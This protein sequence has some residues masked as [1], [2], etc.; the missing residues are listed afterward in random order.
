MQRVL[1]WL[2]HRTGYRNMV[3][4]ALYEPIPGGARWR[5]VWGSTLVFTFMIQVIT[6]FCLWLAYSPSATTAWE[7]VY[8]IQESMTLGWVIRG[9]HHF[10]A[11][12]MVILLVLH[13]M[14][15]VIDGAY[16][17]PREVNFWLG[18][19]LMQIILFLGLTG[20][21][22]PWD[23]KGYYAT[24]V[25]T[26]IMGSAPLVGP[27]MQQLLQGG[28]QY[29]NHTLT[30]FFALHAGLLPALLV[31]FL[32]LH[33]YVFRRHGLHAPSVEGRETGLFWPDQVLRDGV[34]CLAVLAAILT[35]TWYWHGAELMAP[36]DPSEAY[37]AAR[38]E[39]YYLFLFK[40]LKFPIVSQIGE[41][42]HLGEAFGAIVVPGVIMLVLVLM[43]LIAYIKYGHQF[44]VAFLWTVVGIAGVLTGMAWYEDWYANTPEGREFR[45][46]VEEAH[47]ESARV[48]VLASSPTGIPPS[49]AASLLKTDPLT[50]GPE[51]F[52]EFCAG[53]HQP[54]GSE[55]SEIPLA[56]ALTVA[57]QP[58]QI[59]F[60][61][62]E[63]I[64]SVLTEF[65]THFEPLSNIEGEY[66][67]AAGMIL[68]GSMAYWSDSNGPILL[69]DQNSDDF[70]ALVEFLYAQSLRKDAL[71]PDDET[72]LRGR[73]IFS[74]G[75]LASGDVIE[76]CSGCHAM[77]AYT[78]A[79]GVVVL[80]DEALAE[81]MFPDLTGYGGVDWLQR[82]I[83][84]PE[85]VYSGGFG[86]NAMPAFEDQLRREDVEMISRWLAGDYYLPQES[87][88]VPPAAE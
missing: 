38:P 70:N 26:E 71:P 69:E 42:T 27:T 76:A 30:R 1:H 53:C 24:Q 17:A 87:G 32:A 58:T 65:R 29:G 81:E 31:A 62:R 54:V 10:T 61:S 22:L 59:R 25:A 68:E 86:N 77:R 56:P 12:A 19:I 57:D 2:D 16:R 73:E 9:M 64:R 23:Q 49:G 50:R 66:Q 37:D 52:G 80:E 82:F 83:T 43:P 48:R 46:A 55:P 6:G 63:W 84:D 5:Y 44:N 14:Q 67:D 11:Q 28:S 39:W 60:A 18:L 41:A 4:G 78:V 47:H 34:A 51:L 72:V 20:Y 36:A 79:D 15:V 75:E 40:F 35:A 3:S 85:A 74:T 33:I 88:N 8:F 7:S 45:M 13:L 21:L